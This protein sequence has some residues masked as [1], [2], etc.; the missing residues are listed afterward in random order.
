[1]ARTRSRHHRAHQRVIAPPPGP[2]NEETILR[3][4]HRFL[5]DEDEDP[6]ALPW[7]ERVARRYYD[8]LYREYCLC[9]L[10]RYK[11][12]KLA[13]RWRTEA[14]VLSGKG[15]SVC[16]ALRCTSQE[17]LRSWEVPFDYVET[18]RPQRA[19]VKLRLCPS[20]SAKLHHGRRPAPTSLPSPPR[21][22]T[23]AGRDPAS[24]QP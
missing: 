2:V 8:Q 14:E 9:E 24:T 13:M 11:E 20:C 22:D 16:A 10:R 18:G 3:Q 1:D 12:G 5:R 15:E 21:Y 17:D 7:E 19:L 23:A 6:A 4:N